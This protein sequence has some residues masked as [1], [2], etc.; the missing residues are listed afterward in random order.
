MR[1]EVSRNL[2]LEK[3]STGYRINSAADDAAGLTISKTL[4]TRYRGS[5]VARQNVQ[6]SI[7]MLQ[8]AEGSLTVAQ[9]NLH[10]MRE[11]AVKA[12]NGSNG[13]A[14]INAIKKEIKALID[15]SD[16]T[17]DSTKFNKIDLFNSGV[18]RW[19][20]MDVP[21]E[22]DKPLTAVEYDDKLFVFDRGSDKAYS[23]D[24]ERW[25]DEKMPG[26]A[27]GVDNP[28]SSIVY[29]G[30]LYV[31][32]HNNGSAYSYD[33][34]TWKNENLPAMSD[35]EQ[36]FSPVVYD[37]KLY[38]FGKQNNVGLEYDGQNWTDITAGMPSNAQERPAD[39]VVMDGKLY[40]F[41]YRYSEAYSF[42][43]S[44]WT[45]ENMPNSGDNGLERPVEAEVYNGKVYVA[46][47]QDNKIISYD[48]QNWVNENI[49]G[50]IDAKFDLIN[51]DNK[52]YA[53]G[54]NGESSY[55]Y[56]G[57]IWQEEKLPSDISNMGLAAEYDGG[58]AVFDINS[59]KAYMTK[60]QRFQIG[61]GSDD[62]I[63]SSLASK[64]VKFS[65]ITGIS[66]IDDYFNGSEVNENLINRIDKGIEEISRVMSY[67]GSQQNRLQSVA[68]SLDV[69]A[70][71]LQSSESQIKDADFA[72]ESLK[73]V[74]SQILQETSKYIMAQ[75]KQE[76]AIALKLLPGYKN[77]F[78]A[79]SG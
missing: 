29:N 68:K 38:L 26:G 76:A 77:T 49:P 30:K 60:T 40:M 17:I 32:G 1:N 34:D 9:K 53:I 7:S 20:D 22:L 51:Y 27:S 8:T 52:L 31:F 15:Q 21:C 23:Y 11:L 42:D 16:K 14:Q 6:N 37:G 39:P 47:I 72:E 3:L 64:K 41:T 46:S 24:G 69:S 43:G 50:G 10:R 58:L 70:E 63:N 48:G 61:A 66:N 71:N 35:V 65:E 2:S 54:T 67:I 5:N 62:K 75:A 4:N 12:A 36:I 55:S 57:S 79:F 25:R 19:E 74:K 33:G 28:K 18:D 56:D 13:E 44:N 45:N 59:N 73:Y 78:N